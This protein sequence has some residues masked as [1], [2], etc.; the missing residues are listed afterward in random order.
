MVDF[1]KIVF[2]GFGVVGGGIV[3]GLRGGKLLLWLIFSFLF[4]SGKGGRWG[5]GGS[6]GFW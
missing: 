1:F 5:G 6:R 3:V 4:F 2:C